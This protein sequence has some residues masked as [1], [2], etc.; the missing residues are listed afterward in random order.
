MKMQ[1]TMIQQTEQSYNEF[2]TSTCTYASCDDIPTD[3]GCLWGDGTSS[4]WWDG[5]WNCE[6]EGVQVCGL[7][8]V[9]FE[10]NL[11]D[12]ISGTPHVNGTY[13]GWCGSC[14]NAMSDVD[15]DGTWSHIQYFA[16]GEVHDYKFTIDG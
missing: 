15:G 8:Q 7:H 6:G 14:Y 2:N 4:M 9:V 11:P 16:E 5:W 1:L 12:G 3:M 13:N 10:L